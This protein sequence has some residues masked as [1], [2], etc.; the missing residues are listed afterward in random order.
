[1]DFQGAASTEITAL[2]SRQQYLGALASQ[3]NCGEPGPGVAEYPPPSAG[4]SA[5]LA[6]PVAAAAP[7]PALGG[8]VA[9]PSA[10]VAQTAMAAPQPAAPPSAAPPDPVPPGRTVLFPV[11]I[12]HPYYPSSTYVN[13]Q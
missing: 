8:G 10:P 11:T 13:V 9:A 7:L 5:P 1:M 6:P 3:K 2:Q 12:Y 4:T